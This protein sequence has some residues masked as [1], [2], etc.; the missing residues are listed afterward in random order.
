MEI[1]LSN[2]LSNAIKHS[3][4]GDKI[5]I[6]IATE[7]H[8]CTILIKDT[9][10]GIQADYLDKIFDRF[11]QVKPSDS[12]RMTG[13][14]IGLA[15]SKKIVELHHGNIAVTIK[16]NVG[17][18]F[19]IKI[20]M[21]LKLNEED[22][23]ENF[24]EN[25][26]IDKSVIE[27]NKPIID[28]ENIRAKESTLLLIDDNLDILN[29]LTDILSDSY[30]I[31]QSHDGDSGFET[32]SSLV[33]DLI[34]SDVMMP[35]KDGITLCKELKSQVTTSHI[36]II[37]LTAKTSSISEIEGLKTGADDYIAKPFNSKVI[38][39]RISSLLKNRE[40]LRTYLLNKVRFEP[41]APKVE[42]E[43]NSESVFIHKALVLVENNSFNSKVIKARISSLLKN[44][45]KLRTYLLNKVR[46]EPTAPKVENESNSESVFIHKALVLVENNL[47][48]PSFGIHDMVDQ[49]NMSQSTLY[50]KIR[51]LTGLSLTAFIRSV[52]L[53][54]AATLILTQD[55][56][57]N[58]ISFEVGFNDYKYFTVSFKKQFNCLPSKYRE[59]TGNQQLS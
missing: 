53:K 28:K 51:S 13:S 5:N 1:V 26:A 48:N 18:E 59:K 29:Y 7:G 6:K 43:S 14:G 45:E 40:K 38:K 44:R 20:P 55:M 41:T 30:N 37:L 58:Q 3:K 56:S 52:R 39:A 22:G 4:S 46:F 25:D 23:F 11:F 32:A 34:I 2:L 19:L 35:G 49:L 16:E 8:F 27:N 9:G 42:N 21:D 15:F 17:T 24:I 31:I 33:P 50:R 47:D 54:K 10:V 57:L 12:S 36:P